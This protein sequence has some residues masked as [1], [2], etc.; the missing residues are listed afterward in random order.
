M[1][2]SQKG[3]FKIEIRENALRAMKR[4]PEKDK[5]RIADKIDSLADNP[6]AQGNEKLKGKRETLYRIRSGRLQNSL[7]GSFQYYH[8]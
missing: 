6:L 2:E 4:L 5:I 8:R 7:R 1:G 3:T